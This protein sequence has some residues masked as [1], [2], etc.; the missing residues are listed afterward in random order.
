M[1]RHSKIGHQACSVSGDIV[2]VLVFET[3]FEFA[4]VNAYNDRT[5]LMADSMTS[6]PPRE[7]CRAVLNPRPLDKAY[8]SASHDL[9]LIEGLDSY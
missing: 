6:G 3:F 9:S 5:P 8:S 2:C 4:H 1:T 7:N